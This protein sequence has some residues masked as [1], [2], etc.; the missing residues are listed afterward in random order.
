MRCSGQRL[1]LFYRFLLFKY[2]IFSFT[3]GFKKHNDISTQNINFE[4]SI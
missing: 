1:R 3:G 4:G 2:L